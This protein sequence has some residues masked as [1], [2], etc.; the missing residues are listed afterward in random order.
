MFAFHAT[1]LKLWN[2]CR[3][4]AKPACNVCFKSDD[5]EIFLAALCLFT[6]T[7]SVTLSTSQIFPFPAPVTDC[8]EAHRVCS[9][10][11]QCEALYRGLELCAVD[12]AVAPLGEQ[13]A[14]ECLERQDALLAK[15]PSLLACKCQRGFRKEERCLRIYWRVRL[16]PGKLGPYN[17]SLDLFSGWLCI[18]DLGKT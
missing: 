8:V 4:S 7:E 2:A 5:G 6:S 9:T 16:L 17:V 18:T 12:A 3:G 1:F 11:P 10:E 13:E 14:S 15:H